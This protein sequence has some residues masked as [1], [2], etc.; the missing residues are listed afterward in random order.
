M[1]DKTQTSAKRAKKSAKRPA[2][3]QA[4]N[5]WKRKPKSEHRVFLCVLMD[6]QGKARLD[7]LAAQEEVSSVRL[8]S[9]LVADYVATKAG[10]ERV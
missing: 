2:K 7:E 3:K 9:R 4:R 6:P 10:N 5:A 1:N 8:A